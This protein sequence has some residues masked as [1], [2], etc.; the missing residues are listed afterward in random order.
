MKHKAAADPTSARI[1][2]PPYSIRLP[3]SGGSGGIKIS[4]M[5][6]VLPLFGTQPVDV[7]GLVAGAT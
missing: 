3:T 6:A 5:A 7:F 2:A 1:A 4:G